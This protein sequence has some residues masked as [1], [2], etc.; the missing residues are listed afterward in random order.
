MAF[1]L[2]FGQLVNFHVGCVSNGFP[3]DSKFISRGKVMGKL[4]SGTGTSPQLSQKII[5]IGQPQYL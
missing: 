1:L 2:H 3:F 5:G 4:S